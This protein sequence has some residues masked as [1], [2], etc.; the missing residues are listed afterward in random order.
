[1]KCLDKDRTQ[2]Y[3]SAGGLARDVESY[4]ADE[5]VEACPPS[6]TY[7]VRR[8]TRKHRKSL[9]VAAALLALLVAGVVVSTWQAVRATRAEQLARDAAQV[10]QAERDRARMAL[11]RQVAERLDGDLRR[12]A[13][14][15]NV[16]AAT[17][18]PRRD[19]NEADFERWLRVVLQE[20]ERIFGMA[21]AFEPGQLASGRDDFCLYV[22]RGANGIEAKQLLPPQYVPIYRQWD[23][24][25]R[26][27]VTRRAVWSDPYVDVGG[28]NIPMVTFSSPIWRGDAIVGVLTL[29]LSVKYFEVLRSWLD[30]LRFGDHSYGFVVSQSGVFISHPDADYD[31]ARRTGQTRP[32]QIT[33]TA[34]VDGN[35]AGLAQRIQQNGT[36]S[37]SAID[38]VTGQRSTFLFAPVPSA[39]WTF[40]AV[41]ECRDDSA[42]SCT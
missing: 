9:T 19:W 11:T 15:G 40:V 17:I 29:D 38:P 5:P 27:L 41:V 13:M 6:T 8:F 10:M 28:G 21:L 26:P 16:L 4:L 42:A 20:D 31:F 1:M 34:G 37:Q 14:A 2:R 23:W 35:F 7:R 3:E 32:R 39:D 30:E 25:A 18:G 24:Y 22:F 12:L 36:G 33:D